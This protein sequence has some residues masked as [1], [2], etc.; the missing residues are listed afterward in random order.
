MCRCSHYYCEGT[1]ISPWNVCLFRTK[2]WVWYMVLLWSTSVFDRHPRCSN[3]STVVTTTYYISEGLPSGSF[4]GSV[5]HLT[6]DTV[7]FVMAGSTLSTDLRVDTVQNIITTDAVLDREKVP[8]YTITLIDSSTAAVSTVSVNVTD[9]NDNSPSFF[10]AVYNLEFTEGR[11]VLQSLKATDRDFGSNSTQQYSI[12]SGNIGGVFRLNLFTD[13]YG[14][15]CANL[16]LAPGKELDRETRDSY[17]LNISASDGGNP[18]RRGFTLLNITVGDANDNRPIFTNRSYS[19][20]VRENSPVGTS[21]GKV[22]ASDED[23]GAFAQVVYSIVSRS[24]PNSVFN[25]DPNTGVL[26]NIRWLDYES[27]REY[28]INVRA[29]NAGAPFMN[30]EVPVTFHVLDVNDNKPDIRIEF[31]INEY[32]QVLENA[33]IGTTVARIYVSDKDSGINGEVDVEIEAGNG[34]F[35]LRSDPANNVDIIALAKELDRE[36]QSSYKVRI[37]AKDRG[38]PQQVSQDGFIANVGDVND[39]SPKFD[40]AVFTAVL[41][42]NATIGTIVVVAHATDRDAG[43]NAKLTY[44]IT[45]PLEDSLYFTWFQINSSTGEIKTMALLDREKVPRP[46]LHVTVTDSGVPLLSANCTVFINVSDTNDN[47]PVFT[48]PVYLA[49]VV[50]NT[51]NGT[52]VTQVSAKDID[53]AL[54]GVVKYSL[55]DFQKEFPFAINPSTGV[56]T[57][58]GPIDYELH[59]SY[60]I[61]V[62]ATDGGGRVSTS[63]LNISVV[64]VNDN[65]PI[66]SP[67]SYNITVY[68]NLTVSDTVV[69]VTAN[70]SDSGIFSRLTFA[71][72][73]GNGNGNFYIHPST[74]VVTLLKPLD[75]ETQDFHQFEVEATDG[76][77]LKSKHSAVVRVTVLDVNDE[78]PVFEPTFYNFTIV[79]NSDVQTVVGSVHASSKDLGTNADIYYSIKGG[80][81]DNVFTINSTGTVF[82]QGNIDHEKTP[83]L[84]VTIQAKDGG[85][86]PLFGFANVSV[87]VIDLNDNSPSFSSNEIHVNILEDTRVG[88]V[89]YNVTAHDSDSGIFGQVHYTLVFNP[90][91]TFKLDPYSGALSLMHVI[92][93]EGPRKY[94]IQVLA[95]DGGSPSLNATATFKLSVV[96]VNDHPPR[97][98]NSSYIAHVSEGRVGVSDILNV[99]ATD[100][101]TGD[102]ARIL[103]SFEAG[104]DTTLFGIKS[105]GTIF[106]KKALDREQKAVYKFRVVATD[107]GNPPKSSTADVTIYVDDINDSNP[108]FTLLSYVFQVSENSSNRTRVGQVS[109]TDSDAGSNAQ[110]SY[111]FEFPNQQFVI[112]HD[113][114]VIRTNQVLDRETQASYLLTVVASDHGVNPRRDKTSVTVFVDDLNDN[115]PTFR[116][117]SY[118]KAVA[119]NIPVGSFVIKVRKYPFISIN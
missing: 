110:I 16:V 102:N 26:Y 94:T 25:I 105:D 1:C 57:T 98:P 80:N 31:A 20:N 84:L 60:H 86:P 96:D 93:F 66:I 83:H 35:S 70:D 38:H 82:T 49:S 7:V 106:I 34:H 65:Y 113:T 11:I 19:I 114:G 112:D 92:D 15:T 30:D 28:K 61:K 45:Y 99:S 6:F 111:T 109:A 18:P 104:V 89:F 41:S 100:A 74:G 90:N 2:L 67:V 44:N 53:S 5:S 81:V 59:F 17:M 43:S 78:P 64:D 42:E 13:R 88:Q 115:K 73:S 76:G 32:Y 62:L 23:I 79:E 22:F 8:I 4:V 3:A 50:E 91:N 101:D 54:N 14:A 37:F 68:E 47:D 107:Q 56:V 71:F 97:F 24:N 116:K 58:S 48:K 103:Y 12:L 69:N 75:R 119:E 46:V 39:N 51:A 77:G 36:T 33:T 87:T 55:E 118:E 9:L 40:Q 95:E 72:S 29:E 117:L 27:V 108:I 21:I 63:D 85:F 52:L 10:R